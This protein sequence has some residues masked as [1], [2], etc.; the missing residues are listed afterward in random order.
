MP[1]K[2]KKG[3][4]ART[5]D[6]VKTLRDRVKFLATQNDPNDTL[7]FLALDELAKAATRLQHKDADTLMN[8]HVKLSDIKDK[9]IPPHHSVECIG[10]LGDGFSF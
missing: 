2:K 8:F 4:T 5:P 10:G 7:I 3:D 1:K 9:L 6:E